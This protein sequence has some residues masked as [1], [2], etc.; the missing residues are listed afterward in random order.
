MFI[1]QFL[2]FLGGGG[3]STGD[4][5]LT[6]MN[7]TISDNSAGFGGG[8]IAGALTVMNSTISGNVASSVFGGGGIYCSGPVTVTN[9]TFGGNSASA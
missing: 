5:Q 9:S 8:I 6:V 2:L 3:I 7:S 1:R 4:A